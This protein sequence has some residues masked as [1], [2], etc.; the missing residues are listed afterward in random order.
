[1]DENYEESSD[2]ESTLSD[3]ILKE[4]RDAI[5]RELEK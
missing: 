2:A 3:I 1:M 5:A 4:K